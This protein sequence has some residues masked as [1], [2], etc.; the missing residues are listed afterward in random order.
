MPPAVGARLVARCGAGARLQ[1]LEALGGVVARQ[2]RRLHAARLQRLPVQAVEP[3][4]PPHIR[5]LAGEHAQAPRGLALQQPGNQ[6]LRRGQGFIF[7][8]VPGPAAR[9]LGD[10]S[11][12]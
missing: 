1:L 7:A 10:C 5:R 6:V 3:A 8:C 11:R 9:S 12:E 2:A 4:V